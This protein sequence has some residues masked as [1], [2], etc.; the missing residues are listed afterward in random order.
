MKKISLL[1]AT[2]NE[3]D[4]IEDMCLG[5]MKLFEEKLTA[6]DY[7]IVVIDNCS[8]DGTRDKIRLLC[9][10]YPKIK[11]I[12][13][14]KNFGAAK[15]AYYG[16]L[17]TTGDCAIK[18]AAD[19]QDPIEL[20]P[21]FIEEWEN[22]YQ[23]VIGIKSKSEE[24]KIKYF[25]R[26]VYYKIIKKFS[27]VEQIEQYTGFG[28]YDRS[29]LDVCEKLDDSFPYFRGI[30]AELGGKRKEIEYTQPK[31]KKG[32][33]KYKFYTL[34]DTAMLGIT[35]YTKILLRIAT[36]IGF[37][38]AGL[39]FLGAIVFLVLKLMFWYHYPTGVAP[40]MISLFLLSSIQL[41]FIGILG[42]YILNINTRIMKRPLVVEE[43]R[44]NFEEN[45]ES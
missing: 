37:I 42:E 23:I 16:L 25:M 39:S 4:N 1:V 13:N 5:L 14:V 33:S 21:Q 36:I 35:S 24:S 26:G 3:V 27:D 45:A 17:N 2:Y 15:S 32:K 22:G 11:A 18:L 19:F 44:I 30:V 31:R 6:Y 20:I 7:E 43:E 12:L 40:M 29:F 9:N 38:C 34:Y 8:N 41:F 28:L 10:K